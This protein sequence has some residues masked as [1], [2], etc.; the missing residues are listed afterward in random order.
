MIGKL[1]LA[2]AVAGLLALPSAR[3]FAAEGGTTI[4]GH[5]KLTAYDYKDGKM[6][7]IKGHQYSGMRFSGMYL[8][9]SS[10]L[11]DK[12]SI[13]LQPQFDASSTFDASTGATPRFGT[14][15]QESKNP[16]VEPVFS[17]W[18]KAVVKIAL[19]RGYEL[20]AGIVKPRFTI[21]YGAELFWED[22]FNGSRFACSKDLGAMKETG[23]E[24]Y[25]PF[26]VGPISLPA[27]LYIL[28]GNGTTNT[29]DNNN[30][31]MLM[32]HAEPE[33]GAWKFSGS[34]GR[35]RYDNGNKLDETRYSLGG[36]YEWKDLS[37][38]AEYAG[39]LW[40]RSLRRDNGD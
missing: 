35:G 4:G 32:V 2:G 25:K 28:N 39:G 15:L 27:Y 8:Y 1:L 29:L 40:E 19:P 14:K 36:S 33:I 23:V 38:R 24:I 16:A 6:N 3:L 11:T 31:P 9:V 13:D 26:E 17:G 5:I 34:L 20:S 22:E 7:G 21:E 30:S 18:V 10:E 12:I 37:A